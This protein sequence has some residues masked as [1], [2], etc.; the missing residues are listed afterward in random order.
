MRPTNS[1]QQER[2]KLSAQVKEFLSRGGQIKMIPS[3]HESLRT[4]NPY[5]HKQH[6]II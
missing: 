5:N 2:D 1:K 4:N 3:Y 6:G